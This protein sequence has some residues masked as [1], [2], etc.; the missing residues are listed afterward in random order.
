MIVLGPGSN[1]AADACHYL[2][3]ANASVYSSLGKLSGGSRI[4]GPADDAAGS[5]VAMKLTAAFQRLG[6]LEN[7]LLNALSFKQVQQDS[8]KHLGD[9][10]ERMSE[11]KTLSLDPT[12]SASDIAVYSQ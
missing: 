10:L 2:Q 4:V 5:G 1:A 7:N 12:K 3:L 6:A 11:L 9:L 8:L